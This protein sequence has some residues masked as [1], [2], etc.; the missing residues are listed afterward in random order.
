MLKVTAMWNGTGAGTAFSNF[1]F[2]QNVIATPGAIASANA[3]R[4]FFASFAGGYL[5]MGISVQVMPNVGLI[6]PETGVLTDEIAVPQPAVV[7]GGANTERAAPAG[8]VVNWKTSTVI[9]GRRL[10]GKT[11]LVPLA[12]NAYDVDGTLKPATG[13]ALQAAAAGL[14]GS[15]LA[16]FRQL[17]VWHRPV[18]PKGAPKTGGSIAT[19]TS[20]SV[21]DRVAI[22]TSRRG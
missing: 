18:G 5:P 4:A 22:L 17:V 7:N 14:I 10:R 20:S 9:E 8:A 12:L 2:D 16:D 6:E 19:V 1:Y 13:T 3:V 15:V 21:S 11:F